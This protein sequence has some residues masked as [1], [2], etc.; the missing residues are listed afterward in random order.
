MKLDLSD[1]EKAAAKGLITPEQAQ[2]LWHWLS[3][4]KPTSG[5]FNAAGVG[6]YAGALLIIGAMSWWLVEGWSL[7]TG[8]QVFMVGIAYTSVFLGLGVWMNKRPHLHLPASLSIT[9]AV[10]VTPLITYGLQHWLGFW[11]INFPGY[12]FGGPL[13][14]RDGRLTLELTAIISGL[15]ALWYFRFSLLTVP[16]F[17]ASWVFAMDVATHLM[18]APTVPWTVAQQM[19]LYYGAALLALTFTADRLKKPNWIFWGYLIGLMAFWGG[20]TSHSGGTEFTK[21]IYLLTNLGLIGLSVY[22]RRKTFV[23]FGAMGVFIYVGHLA[24]RVFDQALLFPFIL[25]AIGLTLLL[26]GVYLHHKQTKKL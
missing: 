26:G 8:P 25:S 3:A 17:I 22:L 18:N 4:Q 14:N 10:C 7:L 19:S 21:F 16:I 9:V 20:L 13:L 1:L 15:I 12:F 2:P 23:L 6:S 11:E 5:S 24:Y